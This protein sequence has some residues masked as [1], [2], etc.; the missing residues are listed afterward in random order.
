MKQARL[1]LQETTGMSEHS[2]GIHTHKKMSLNKELEH[3]LQLEAVMLDMQR[4]FQRK[5]DRIA[6][7]ILKLGQLLGVDGKTRYRKR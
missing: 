4:D 6:K 2:T 5:G 3:S 1:H 7:N